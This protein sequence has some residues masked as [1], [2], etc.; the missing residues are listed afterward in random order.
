MRLVRLEIK[1]PPRL[2]RQPQQHGESEATGSHRIAQRG[3]NVR[4]RMAGLAWAAVLLLIWLCV[5][6]RVRGGY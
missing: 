1:A 2:A 3:G 5:W 6:E 4:G